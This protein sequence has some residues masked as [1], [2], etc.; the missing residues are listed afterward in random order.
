[1]KILVLCDDY[2][3]PAATPRAGLKPLA[4]EDIH[5][6][7]IEN[8][9]EWSPER[10]K[11]YSLTILTKSNNT[12]SK[13]QSAW[14]TPNI[15]DALTDYVRRG[16][17]LLAIHSGIADYEATPGL[18]RL[19]GGK[20]VH[21]PDPCPVTL[22]PL[23][24][25]PLNSGVEPFS[26]HD[27]HYFVAM[28]DPQAEIFLTTTSIHGEQPGAWR[29]RE[30]DGRVAVITPGHN[31]EVWLHQGFQRLLRNALMWCAASK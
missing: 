3:H 23:T 21:H 12:S 31:P 1:M 15:A 13:D 16:N 26:V 22:S 6:D 14:M 24:T 11:P 10:M 27:E 19:L 9:R 20:F 30:K 2:W 4:G 25:H 5:F 28:E 8:A 7:W 18:V 29:R 17:G